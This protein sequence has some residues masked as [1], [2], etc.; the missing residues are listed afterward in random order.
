MNRCRMWRLTPLPRKKQ[1]TRH[2]LLVTSATTAP[3]ALEAEP[4]V[5]EAGETPEEL[6]DEPI[7]LLSD[8]DFNQLTPSEPA[9]QG[10]P[11]PEEPE[12]AAALPSMFDGLSLDFDDLPELDGA[13]EAEIPP[14]EES[15]DVTDNEALPPL[16]E[17]DADD[18]A[19]VALPETAELPDVPDVRD[20]D[21][22]LEAAPADAQPDGPVETTETEDAP[23][24]PDVV[25]ASDAVVE[26]I[27]DLPDEQTRLIGP[28]RIDL[29]LYNVYLNEADEWSRRLG[30]VLSEW[31][32]ECHEP[33]PEQA[34]SLAHSLAG[35]SATVGF[36]PLSDISRALEHALGAVA[37]HQREGRP[38]QQEQAQL[39]VDASEDIR[40]LLHQFAAGFFKEP[41]PNLLE[42]LHR[43]LHD[44]PR[45]LAATRSISSC[46]SRWDAGAACQ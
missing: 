13:Q 20:A 32:L 44:L 40:R 21:Q 3:A 39:F 43:L 37:L 14:T 33:V 36:Q 6:A 29:K 34:E 4:M 1:K 42:A 15:V 38:A 26:Q 46:T 23:S 11:S 17:T 9:P 5:G 8:L 18:L 35:S 41:Q 19:P 28:L 45:R 27:A 25:D 31:L 7:S 30:T 12:P 2:G 10:D 22:T 24:S 16:A